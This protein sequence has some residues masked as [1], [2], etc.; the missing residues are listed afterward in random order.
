MTLLPASSGSAL[1]ATELSA[2]AV[3]GTIRLE[4]ESQAA[5]GLQIAAQNDKGLFAGEFLRSEGSNL[6]FLRAGR[7]FGNIF[8]AELR[9]KSSDLSWF[10]DPISGAP[11]TTL[12]DLAIYA[13]APGFE[14]S[15]SSVGIHYIWL[16]DGSPQYGA[17]V[18]RS[19]E[20]GRLRLAAEYGFYGT[21]D[22]RESDSESRPESFIPMNFGSVRY[23]LG[24]GADYTL[25]SHRGTTAAISAWTDYLLAHPT[26]AETSPSRHDSS[27]FLLLRRGGNPTRPADP[28]GR[29]IVDAAADSLPTTSNAAYYATGLRLAENKLW[30][31]REIKGTVF[32]TAPVV[33][34]TEIGSQR[35]CRIEIG[36]TLPTTVEDS[37]VLEEDSYPY[38]NAEVHFGKSGPGRFSVEAQYIGSGIDHI[39]TAEAFGAQ[40]RSY[41]AGWYGLIS[42]DILLHPNTRMQL[43]YVTLPSGAVAA[44]VGTDLPIYRDRVTAGLSGEVTFSSAHRSSSASSRFSI[45]GTIGRIG[46]AR[47]YVK[48]QHNSTLQP[49]PVQSDEIVTLYLLKRHH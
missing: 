2:D 24:G 34:Y 41:L 17:S 1:A 42:G 46:N 15:A 30:S 27:V 21:S 28:L 23:M 8:G 37:S 3:F 39:S 33:G 32:S 36:A 18:G 40:H 35:S 43:G 11:I 6:T 49:G 4:P 10:P 31:K 19:S 13:G 25:W 5:Y 44:R 14:N 16:D 9:R 45:Q 7:R 48:Y 47:F 22:K 38:L 20:F 29:S 12:T 26:V